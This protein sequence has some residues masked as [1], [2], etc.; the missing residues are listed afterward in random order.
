DRNRRVEVAVG[1]HRFERNGVR[2]VLADELPQFPVEGG[3]TGAEGRVGTG[4][5]HPGRRRP[6]LC[7]SRNEAVAGDRQAGIDAENE[8]VFCSL[9]DGYDRFWQSN[10]QA[11]AMTFSITV[12]SMS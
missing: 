4:A 6:G 7:A 12:S 3:Q 5:N 9:G 1:E 10:G 2:A 11:S 8:H